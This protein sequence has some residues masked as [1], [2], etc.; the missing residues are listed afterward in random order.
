MSAFLFLFAFSARVPHKLSV[1]SNFYIFLFALPENW[2][3]ALE[4]EFVSPPLNAFLDSASHSKLSF[5]RHI[6][7]PFFVSFSSLEYIFGELHIYFETKIQIGEASNMT[8]KIYSKKVRHRKKRKISDRKVYRYL[9]MIMLL[10]RWSAT[11]DVCNVWMINSF[12]WYQN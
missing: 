2:E 5:I 8:W 10:L 12:T 7:L 1:T 3:W 6:F 11:F 4:N 9:V